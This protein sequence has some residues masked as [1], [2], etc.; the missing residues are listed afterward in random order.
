MANV[1]QRVRIN[2]SRRLLTPGELSLL[3]K[4]NLVAGME[5]T[6]NYFLESKHLLGD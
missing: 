6:K 2:A 4:G 3:K 5:K 1:R